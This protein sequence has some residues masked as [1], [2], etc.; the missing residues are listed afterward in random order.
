MPA[1]LPGAGRSVELAISEPRVG[2]TTRIGATAAAALLCAEL[3]IRPS[4][5]VPG[6]SSLALAQERNWRAGRVRS[7]APVSMQG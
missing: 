7:G 4:S 2:H 6:R 5:E 3:G 1:G